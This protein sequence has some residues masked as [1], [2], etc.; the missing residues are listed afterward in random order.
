MFVDLDYCMVMALLL[1]PVKRPTE[2]ERKMGCKAGVWRTWHLLIGKV[3][4]GTKQGWRRIMFCF[5]NKINWGV[6]FIMFSVVFALKYCC[7]MRYYNDISTGS[8]IGVP[9]RIG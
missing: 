8:I 4:V 1:Y 5:Q 3:V 6:I 9:W 2:Q 7:H